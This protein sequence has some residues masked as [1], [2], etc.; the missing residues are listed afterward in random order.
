M[1]LVCDRLESLLTE[2]PMSLVMLLGPLTLFFDED[3][4]YKDAKVLSHRMLHSLASL[5][6]D[7]PQVLLTQTMPA[8]R[9]LAA[10]SLVTSSAPSMSAYGSCRGRRVT[11]RSTW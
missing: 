2:H 1:T 5:L 4:T 11:G 6:P 8:L 3:V 7:G 9:P 10:A